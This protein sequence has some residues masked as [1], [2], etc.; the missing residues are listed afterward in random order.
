MT[1]TTRS[2]PSS[3]RRWLGIGLVLCGVFGFSLNV[4]FA[5]MIFA[6]GA[7]P[8]TLVFARA[9]GITVILVPVMA[10]WGAPIMLP[11]RERY[12][13]MLLGVVFSV[14]ALA[15]YTGIS[16]IPI[17]IAALIEYT[18]PFQ[19][20]LFM[21]LFYGEP[22][23]PLRLVAMTAAFLGIALTLEFAENGPLNPL[24]VG[25]VA[26][27]SVLTAAM[28]L[29]ANH[30]VR[31]ADSRRMSL[32]STAT[33]ALLY[34]VLYLAT[35]LEPA[36]PQ[37]PGGWILFLAAPVIY[38]FSMLGF[39]TGLSMVGASRAAILANVEPIFILTLAIPLLGEWLTPPQF[40]GAGL[41][42]GGIFVAQFARSR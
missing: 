18:Y 22:L 16:L 20:V 41:V 8:M 40:V 27:A 11:R 5:P 26:V 23:T 28:I 17:S 21:R 19:I 30:V 7:D 1:T 37:T 38:L 35:D 33:M 36:L 10:A 24:G 32:H 3:T 31:R 25:I 15:Y 6:S 14:Q 34:G 29:I 4:V 9:L 39:F 42:I 2:P 12:G 13:S